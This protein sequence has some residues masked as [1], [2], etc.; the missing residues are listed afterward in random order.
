MTPLNQPGRQEAQTGSSSCPARALGGRGS[1]AGTVLNQRHE[2][3]QL[4]GDIA[5]RARPE[6]ARAAREGRASP[7]PDAGA[8]GLLCPENL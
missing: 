1:P 5:H 8:P 2:V 3:T 4:S 6:G 7:P